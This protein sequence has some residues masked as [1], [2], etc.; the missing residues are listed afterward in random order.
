MIS[1]GHVQHGQTAAVVHTQSGSTTLDNIRLLFGAEVSRELLHLS[2]E[3]PGLKFSIDGY[4]SNANFNKKKST[5]I[6]FINRK[7]V[8]SLL[9]I[10]T[11]TFFLT[12]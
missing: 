8:P 1:S 4:I 3:D 11:L 7:S 5:F 2:H 12:L 10:C 6:L 9:N